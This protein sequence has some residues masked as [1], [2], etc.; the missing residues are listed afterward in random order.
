MI[1]NSLRWLEGNRNHSFSERIFLIW[2]N[3]SRSLIT[4]FLEEWL[5][6]ICRRG[7]VLMTISSSLR[8]TLFDWQSSVEIIWNTTRNNNNNNNRTRK[9]R[10]GKRRKNY[11]IVIYRVRSFFLL[12]RTVAKKELTLR[13]NSSSSS[14]DRIS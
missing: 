7:G 5:L 3:S 6:V 8:R 2:D 9:E 12:L 1:A 14:N 4:I 10:K 11:I 13:R